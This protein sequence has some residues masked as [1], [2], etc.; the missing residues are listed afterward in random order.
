MWGQKE[1]RIRGGGGGANEREP[2][3]DLGQHEQR[4]K[5]NESP[6]KRHKCTKSEA[7]QTPESYLKETRGEAESLPGGLNR[8]LG[9]PTC[10]A[11][12]NGFLV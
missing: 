9:A 8:A 11:Q 7:C 1:K 6:M 12:S 3:S 4:S 10:L 2:L 5:E